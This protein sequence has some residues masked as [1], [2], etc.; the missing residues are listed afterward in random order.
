MNVQYYCKECRHTV[1]APS[2]GEPPC[3]ENRGDACEMEQVEGLQ[4]KPKK[5]EKKVSK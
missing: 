5:V 1:Y 2:G 3:R 4:P